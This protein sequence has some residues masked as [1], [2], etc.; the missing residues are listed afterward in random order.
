MLDAPACAPPGAKECTLPHSVTLIDGS[1]A[2]TSCERW[3]HECE[4]RSVVNRPTLAE[5]RSY[6]NTVERKRGKAARE[7]LERTIL[8]LWKRERRKAAA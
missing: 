6:L 8:E 3:R 5:R 7:Q 1:T 4:A 2:C